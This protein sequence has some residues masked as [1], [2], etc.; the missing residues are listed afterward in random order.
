MPGRACK[1]RQGRCASTNLHAG[2]HRAAGIAEGPPAIF[3]NAHGL[4]CST[5]CPCTCRQPGSRGWCPAHRLQAERSRHSARGCMH[6]QRR[7]LM[8]TW[9][10]EG[11]PGHQQQQ[12]CLRICPSH[13]NCC[14]RPVSASYTGRGL[15]PPH[16]EVDV[17]DRAAQR[18]V[19]VCKIGRQRRSGAQLGQRSARL[20]KLLM[21]PRGTGSGLQPSPGFEHA[22]DW[23][24]WQPSRTLPEPHPH[25]GPARRR[26]GAP[27]ARAHIRRKP[28]QGRA[29]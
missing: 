24:L 7:R 5:C 8:R 16:L 21:R 25:P 15:A 11:G 1:E 17:F 4:A 23:D 29:P 20:S 14:G 2:R 26:S 9:V 6:G 27:A 13:L 12:G 22:D 28:P 10:Q 3:E 19:V 18:R